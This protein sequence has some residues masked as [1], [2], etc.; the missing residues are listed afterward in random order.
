MG[1]RVM[2]EVPS[3]G[4][5]KTRWP[6]GCQHLLEKHHPVPPHPPM[7][8][9]C[10]LLLWREKALQRGCLLAP[11]FRHVSHKWGPLRRERESWGL[12]CWGGLPCSCPLTSREAL[13]IPLGML[14]ALCLGKQMLYSPK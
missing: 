4:L 5:L 8:P 2:L 11:G 14:M 12:L 6:Q 1:W 9:Q 3:C 7:L 13:G 10:C